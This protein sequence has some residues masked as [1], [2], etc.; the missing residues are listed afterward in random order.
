MSYYNDLRRQ[1]IWRFIKPMFNDGNAIWDRE[2]KMKV[3]IL[4]QPAWIS[5]WHYADVKPEN[6]FDP[7]QYCY[8][9]KDRLY[10]YVFRPLCVPSH[11]HHCWKIVASPE[12]V[13]QLFHID[14]LQ[15]QMGYESKCGGE[16]RGTTARCWGAYW[17]ARSLHEGRDCYREVRSRMDDDP[18]LRPVKLILKRGC[19]EYEVDKVQ[20]GTD[21]WF[22]TPDQEHLEKLFYDLVLFDEPYDQQPEVIIDI[23]QQWIE[24]AAAMGDPTADIY[25][26]GKP[27]IA[28][29]KTYHEE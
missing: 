23:K 20:G 28:P 5:P 9:W 13:Q 2:N 25:N 14:E 27:I 29:V 19:T 7:P 10:K 4:T 17:Y 21:K 24:H 22:I 15:E 26:D 6:K 16:L 1:N 11:C 3:R 18:I 12:N 8:V